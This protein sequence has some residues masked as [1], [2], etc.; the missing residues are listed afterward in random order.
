MAGAGARERRGKQKATAAYQGI[1]STLLPTPLTGP[2]LGRAGRGFDRISGRASPQAERLPPGSL[3]SL[4][5]I[6]HRLSVASPDT[7][8]PAVLRSVAQ[9]S[10]R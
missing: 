8:V 3:G 7:T 2:Q 9:H 1:P 4:A 6:S 10:G 5:C